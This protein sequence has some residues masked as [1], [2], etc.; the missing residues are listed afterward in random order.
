[1]SVV[2][3]SAEAALRA[4]EETEQAGGFAEL[5]IDALNPS[6]RSDPA[7]IAS[8]V[9][10]RAAILTHRR[11][12]D[13]GLSETPEAER[14]SLLAEAAIRSRVWCDIE[15]D[16]AD[17]I[18]RFGLDA[19]RVIVSHHDT[20]STP[21]DLPKIVDRL[22]AVPAAVAKIATTAVLTTDLFA[23]VEQLE[24]ARSL[25]RPLVAIAMGEK[26][27]ATRI[28]GPAWGAPFTFCSRAA[29]REGAAGQIALYVMRDRYR[30]DQLTEQSFVIGLI[31]G[32]TA[33]SRSPAMHNRVLFDTG[34]DGV[35]LPFTV[36]DLPAFLDAMVRPASRR[37]PWTVRGF[38]VTNP[39]KTRAVD[40]VN[41]LDPLA[42]RVGAINTIVVGENGRLSGFNTDVEGAM[43]PLEEAFGELA[44]TRIGVIGAGGAARA[45]VAGLADRGALTTVFARDIGRARLV[46]DALGTAAGCLD[47]V[48]GAG[49]DV[50]VNAT[51]VGTLGDSEGQSPVPASA[52]A[53]VRL[54]FDLVYAPERTQLLID[55]ESRGCIAL[56]GRPMLAAQAAMQ[57]ELWTGKRVSC[58]QMAAAW[59]S[60]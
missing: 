22:L 37:V 18:H 40:L 6:L 49:L 3:A 39:H 14:I 30:A 46:A 25:G 34:T 58:E 15:M 50:L 57:F 1:M 38:S 5:R 31:A 24:R 20:K 56:G 12:S 43:A 8:L 60:T 17:A 33:Y 44:G 35:Y 29:G 4:I 2:E 26:G 45:V 7:A 21:D 53:G 47:D 19:S 48:A 55:A 23:L 28:L 59:S 36:D 32:N 54:V 11:V 13:G 42:A 27:A 52:L 41:E 10:G 51:P 9:R 16:A